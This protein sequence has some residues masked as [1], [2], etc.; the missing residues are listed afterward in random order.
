M[1]RTLSRTTQT[2]PPLP[3]L[4]HDILLAT[5]ND[6]ADLGGIAEKISREP[7][8]AARIIGVTNSAFYQGSRPIHSVDGAIVRLGV[9]RVRMLALS[10]LLADSFDT[11]KCRAFKP[12]LYWYQAMGTAHCASLIA[13]A[14]PKLDPEM[15]YLGG[16]LH[17]IGLLLLVNTF[18]SQMSAILTAREA[19]PARSLAAQMREQLG[20][21]HHEA[22][23][24]L[25]SSWGL[26]PA[27]CA[28]TEAGSLVSGASAQAPLVKLIDFC[29]RWTAA[30]YAMPP[31][32]NPLQLPAERLEALSKDCRQQQRQL[33]DY[34]HLLGGA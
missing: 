1:K 23:E 12:E 27:I 13:P 32:G 21:D 17:N 7:S 31:P 26:S 18:P 8:I 9:R 14:Q 24:L 4:A 25:L 3:F 22:G 10:T 5:T 2:L 19:E 20:T 6:D 28:T 30:D 34:A 29:A 16:L 15:A 11:K 33:M